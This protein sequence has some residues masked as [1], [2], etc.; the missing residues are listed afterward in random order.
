MLP[1]R[2]LASLTVGFLRFPVK[3][4]S[5]CGTME[6]TWKQNPGLN[7]SLITG[8]KVIIVCSGFSV[9]SLSPLSFLQI[10]QPAIANI[11]QTMTLPLPSSGLKLNLATPVEWTACLA[12]A[13][14]LLL[15]FVLK[16][17]ASAC[18]GEDV[19]NTP[20][21]NN[22]YCLR[23]V[24]LVLL[25]LHVLMLFGLATGVIRTC[26]CANLLFVFPCCEA[27]LASKFKLLRS[28]AMHA[29][30]LNLIC[31]T[32]SNA[33]F[34]FLDFAAAG[35]CIVEDVSNKPTAKGDATEPC[36][37]RVLLVQHFLICRVLASKRNEC[38]H[39]LSEKNVPC[40]CTL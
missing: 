1:L 31:Y 36:L 28:H 30:T 38:M 29:P 33:S 15:T 23:C 37:G 25:V 16:S 39:V 24:L 40:N 11:K 35:A 26:L 6:R 8:M 14:L 19:N 10:F 3:S 9:A 32:G 5:R 12:A 17:A 7:S 27:Y 2:L 22:T 13:F 18:T 20:T 34:F 4:T 21:T